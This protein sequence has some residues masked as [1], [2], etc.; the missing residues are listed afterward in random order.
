VLRQLFKNSQTPLPLTYWF[1]IRHFVDK[2]DIQ[3]KEYSEVI[4][5]DV[6]TI[7]TIN[8]DYQFIDSINSC[9]DDIIKQIKS[10]EENRDPSFLSNPISLA[11]KLKQTAGNE[12]QH[13]IVSEFLAENRRLK[14]QLAEFPLASE[15][16]P[17]K[18]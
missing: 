12:E 10:I 9:K 8:V 2:P 14:T 11:K 5:F 4:P 17:A 1:A 13:K 3:I 18:N 6:T 16:K 15:V 7:R